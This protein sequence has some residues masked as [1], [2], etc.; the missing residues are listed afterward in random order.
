[1]GGSTWS[2][3]RMWALDP[4]LRRRMR[5]LA[6]WVVAATSA[7]AIRFDGIP[8]PW[9]ARLFVF[10]AVGASVQAVAHKRLRADESLARA[11]AAIVVGTLASSVLMHTALLTF[12][13][14]LEGMTLI[15]AAIGEFLLTRADGARTGKSS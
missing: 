15:L 6:V 3:R 7:Y 13:R 14:S 9:R 2:A 10:L 1:V 5:L 12:P 11:E 4:S 8:T